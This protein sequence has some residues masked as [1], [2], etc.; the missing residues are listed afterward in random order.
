[1]ALT[2]QCQGDLRQLMFCFFS[3]LNRRTDFYLVPPVED[4]TAGVAKMGFPE[5][6]AEKLLLA[7]FRQFPL[8]RIPPKKQ[9]QQQQQQAPAPAGPSKTSITD[10][11]T[12]VAVAA[13]AAAAKNDNTAK[14]DASKEVASTKETAAT[15]ATAGDDTEQATETKKAGAGAESSETAEDAVRLTEEGVQIPVGNGGSTKRY[16]WTQT[17]EECSVLIAIPTELHAKDL[18]VTIKAL[19][20]VV[21]TKKPLAGGGE[22]EVHTFLEGD[23]FDKCVPD[24]STWTLEGGVMVIQLYKQLRTFWKTIVQGDDEIDTT[25]VD[26]RRKIAEYDESTQAEIRKIMFDQNQARKGLPVSPPAVP[27]AKATIPPL[28]DGVEY[29]DQDILN[30]KTKTAAGAKR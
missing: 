8:R 18:S 9:Q 6:D 25:L 5:G 13:A 17:T 29:I 26:S 10:I 4:V 1:V 20:V 30:E 22:T 27:G 24:E 12:P 21:K 23:L 28:P 11:S 16:K 19:S 7:A 15:A 14:K 3:F 2:N